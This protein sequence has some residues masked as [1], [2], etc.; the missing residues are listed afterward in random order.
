MKKLTCE[1]IKKTEFDILLEFDRICKENNI[2]YYLCGGTLLGAIR[3]KGFIPWDDDIDVMLSRNEYNKLIGIL[4]KKINER[5][6]RSIHLGNSDF[7]FL[8]VFDLNTK[9]ESVFPD[10]SDMNHVWIDV[11]PIDGL[12]ANENKV[13]RLYKNVKKLRL[14]LSTSSYKFERTESFFRTFAKLLMYPFLKLIGPKR[15][16]RWLDRAAQSYKFDDC[17]YIGGTVWGYGPQERLE[18]EAWLESIDVEFEGKIFKAPGNWKDYLRNL[19]GNY[20]ELPPEKDR[21][22]HSIVAWKLE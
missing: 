5:K 8:K 13:K 9:I 1:E 7:P 15:W 14:A 3:H 16:G 11:F 21:I 20:M 18:K 19:Y 22:N 10:G 17:E 6:Y 4:K 2:T 12:P